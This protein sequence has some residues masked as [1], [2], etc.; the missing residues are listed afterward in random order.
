MLLLALVEQDARSG[1]RLGS[2]DRRRPG[3]NFGGGLDCRLVAEPLFEIPG[4]LIDV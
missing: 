2:G 1:A 4:V 3:S